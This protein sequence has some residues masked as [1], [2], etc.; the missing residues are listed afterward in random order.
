MAKL[1]T[2][3]VYPNEPAALVAQAILRGN[4]IESVL[5]RNDAGGMEPQLQFVSGVPLLVSEGDVNSAV[6]LLQ[7]AEG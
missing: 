2:V 7:D 3:K 1:V 5:R 6:E 4:G